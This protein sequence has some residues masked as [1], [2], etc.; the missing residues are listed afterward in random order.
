MRL[1]ETGGTAPSDAMLIMG[2]S[3]ATSGCRGAPGCCCCGCWV[4]TSWEA[5]G[6]AYCG[7]GAEAEVRWLYGG[8]GADGGGGADAGA[9]AVGGGAYCGGGA[10]Y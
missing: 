4:G 10:A 3:S 2:G 7:G 5:T 9:A 1:A 8:V 6:G